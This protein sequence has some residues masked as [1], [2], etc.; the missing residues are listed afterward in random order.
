M[1]RDPLP[2]EALLD[3]QADI[4]PSCMYCGSSTGQSELVYTG[5]F[6]SSEGYEVWF[7]C[8]GCRN[9]GRPCETFFKTSKG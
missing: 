1:R 7:C 6:E 4:N 9:H 2:S 8:H 3:A 5:D